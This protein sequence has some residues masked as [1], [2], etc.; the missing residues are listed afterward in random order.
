[1]GTT[2]AQAVELLLKVQSFIRPSHDIYVSTPLFSKIP[3]E[4]M[5]VPLTQNHIETLRSNE[6]DWLKDLILALSK[7]IGESDN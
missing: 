4:K 3:L 6:K 2:R 1:M 5:G 7:E